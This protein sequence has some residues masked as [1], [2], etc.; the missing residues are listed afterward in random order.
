VP[1][2]PGEYDGIPRDDDADGDGIADESDVCPH[3]FD[4]PRPLD[5][6]A[7]ADADADG[8]GD[9]CDP[10]PLDPTPGSDC[11]R[12]GDRDGDGAPDGSDLCP[13]A[14]DPLQIDA[15]GDGRGDACDWCDAPN[16]G[17]FPCIVPIARVRDPG[18]PSRPPRHALLEIR[19][20]VVSALR[21]DSGSSRGFYL[22][23]AGTPYAGLF[24][25]TGKLS[26]GVAVGDRLTLRGRYDVYYELDEL[27]APLLLEQAP[28]EPPVPLAVAVADIG[29]GGPLAVAYDSMLISVSET[30]VTDTNPDAPSDY[31][32]TGLDGAL[33]LDDL[34]SPELDNLFAPG[35]R[36]SNVTGILGRSFEHQK[37]Y[38][39]DAADLA[40]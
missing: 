9:A 4:P 1:A 11:S 37:L 18:A 35:T 2:R 26:P 20:A 14:S 23:D 34:L 25:Y 28:G 5:D 19:D 31:D 21:P 24:A 36:F 15:D 27:V 22:V 16:P 33:R 13:D 29:D 30:S 38:P 39:R 32:E 10:C 8:L 40:E 3:V 12:F 7:Q 6:G 17:V